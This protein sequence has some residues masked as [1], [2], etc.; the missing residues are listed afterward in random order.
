LLLKL[1]NLASTVAARAAVLLRVPPER[2]QHDRIGPRRSWVCLRSEY[3]MR[4]MPKPS[5]SAEL[6][7][8]PT[9][10]NYRTDDE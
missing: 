3:A 7:L 8:F 1:H 6:F 9:A 4:Y 5:A 10:E 2:R